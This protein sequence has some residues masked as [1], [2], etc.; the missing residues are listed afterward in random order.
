M[1]FTRR[2]VLAGAAAVPLA[3]A[4]SVTRASDFHALA[5]T[6]SMGWN[7]WDSFGPTIREDEAR[8]NAGIMAKRL[9]PHGW[10]IFTVDIQWYEP[11][12]N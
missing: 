12:A 6:P 8:A 3:V 11:G 7:S 2:D 5:P 9:L 4:P 10:N 1:R